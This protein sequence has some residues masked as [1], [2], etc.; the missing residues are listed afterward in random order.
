MASFFQLFF[1]AAALFFRYTLAA[2]PFGYTNR[3]SALNWANLD[4]AYAVCATGIYQSPINLDSTIPSASSN[5]IINFPPIPN[6]TVLNTGVL[7]EIPYTS[8]NGTT[9]YEGHTYQIE[10]FHFHVPGEHR[11]NEEGYPSEMHMVHQDVRKKS[12]KFVADCDSRLLQEARVGGFVGTGTGRQR[13]AV[14]GHNHRWSPQNPKVR[15]QHHDWQDR[16]IRRDRCIGFVRELRLRRF[17]YAATVH[18]GCCLGRLSSNIPHHSQTSQCFDK[19]PRIQFK[20]HSEQ[21][22]R[23]QSAPNRKGK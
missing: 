5:P 14:H 23:W 10:Q 8:V 15:Y 9:H 1:I 3:L 16:H 7:V 6:A 18:G 13:I 11:V 19:G 22:R 4:P 20:I 17:T 21:A 12:R 2:T